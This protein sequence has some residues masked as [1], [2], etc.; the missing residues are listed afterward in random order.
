MKKAKSGAS[1][2]PLGDVEKA[3]LESGASPLPAAGVTASVRTRPR[4][5]EEQRHV[6]E[7]VDD[8]R[9]RHAGEHDDEAGQGRAD[10]PALLKTTLLRAIA[11]GRCSRPTSAGKRASRAGWFTPIRKPM[12][13]P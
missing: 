7:R 1:T 9:R 4:Q 5:D 12:R 13:A 6:A 2:G 11:V 8:Q 10:E 3:A